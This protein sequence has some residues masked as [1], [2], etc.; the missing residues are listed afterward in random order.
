VEYCPHCE[1]R[2]DAPLLRDQA[3]VCCSCGATLVL[4]LDG[5]IDVTPADGREPYVL[6]A[7]ELLESNSA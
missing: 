5:D 6:P 4:R 7:E 2:L 1:T 3:V